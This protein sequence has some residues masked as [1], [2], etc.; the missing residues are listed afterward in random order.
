VYFLGLVASQRELFQVGRDLNAQTGNLSPLVAAGLFYLLLTVPLTH[1]VNY[2]DGRLRRG[3]PVSADDPA[4]PA[5]PASTQEM[6]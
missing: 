1:L 5:N 3:R 4:S 2:I 6:V